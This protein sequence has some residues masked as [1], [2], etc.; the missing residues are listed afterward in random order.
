MTEMA[1]KLCGIASAGETR[2]ELQ[3]PASSLDQAIRLAQ[4]GDEAA[5]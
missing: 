1:I 5:F 3:V 2:L 4:R